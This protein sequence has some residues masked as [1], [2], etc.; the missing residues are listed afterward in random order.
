M[1]YNATGVRD[2]V[3]SKCVKPIIHNPANAAIRIGNLS[4]HVSH[5]LFIHRGLIVCNKCGC[6]AEKVLH[7]LARLCVPLTPDD[8]Y[9]SGQQNLNRIAKGQL[10]IGMTRWP[11]EKLIQHIL[12]LDVHKKLELQFQARSMDISSVYTGI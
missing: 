11:D 4:T 1:H 6:R 8:K 12:F 10:P 3:L 7:N 2:W 5:T 9:T